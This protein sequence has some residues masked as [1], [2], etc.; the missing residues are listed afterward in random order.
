MG[1]GGCIS[2]YCTTVIESYKFDIILFTRFAA[3][4]YIIM[5]YLEDDPGIVS[6]D[7]NKK[8]GSPEI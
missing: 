8:T 1:D 5:F 3:M 6:F 7:D 2:R 4:S